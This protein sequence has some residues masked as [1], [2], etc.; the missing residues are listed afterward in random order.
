MKGNERQIFGVCS[1]LLCDGL[2]SQSQ[3]GVIDEMN[4]VPGRDPRLF[5]IFGRCRVAAV[6]ALPHQM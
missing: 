4:V 5:G 1:H 3:N 2:H 6:S